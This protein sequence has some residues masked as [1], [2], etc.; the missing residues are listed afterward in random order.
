MEE[1][2][3]V[4]GLKMTKRI[5]DNNV[6]IEISPELSL[7]NSVNP[8]EGSTGK[9]DMD[10]ITVGEIIGPSVDGLRVLDGPMHEAGIIR[11]QGLDKQ[12]TWTRLAC[13]DYGPMELLKEGAKSILGKR[14]NHVQQLGSL[15]SIDEQTGKRVKTGDVS[16]SIEATGVSEHHCQTQ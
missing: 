8:G 11:P 3:R 14:I 5:Y 2:K 7:A 16:Q 1:V 12:R 15:D 10:E 4:L 6:N 13:M 9:D